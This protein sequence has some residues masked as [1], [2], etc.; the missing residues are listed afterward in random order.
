MVNSGILGKRKEVEKLGSAG[1]S[2]I[3]EIYLC[4]VPEFSG[5]GSKAATA[6]CVLA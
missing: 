2:I 3:L 6:V 1:R 5:C 4:N